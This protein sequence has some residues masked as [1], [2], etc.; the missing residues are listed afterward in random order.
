[1]R[2]SKR[3]RTDD[4]IHPFRPDGFSKHAVQCAAPTFVSS[5]DTR[6]T[7]TSP[8][9]I[10]M[11]HSRPSFSSSS[12][13]HRPHRRYMSPAHFNDP[14][15]EPIDVGPATARKS[16][17]CTIFPYIAPYNSNM[18]KHSTK[19]FRPEFQA[20][21]STSAE[22]LLFPAPPPHPTRSKAL[23]SATSQVMKKPAIPPSLPSLP[24]RTK[25]VSATNIARCFDLSSESGPMD[26]LAVTLRSMSDDVEGPSNWEEREL[27]RGLLLSPSKGPTAMARTTR[28]HVS[29][30]V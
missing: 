24:P 21:T 13:Q 30:V 16:L 23:L 25:P 20:A 28:K 15:P 29:C 9:A 14:R 4:E 18:M 8:A 5:F 11:L 12:S 19:P 22:R 6:P 3:P 26:S 17:G 7:N 1:M 2:P 27:R 10:P